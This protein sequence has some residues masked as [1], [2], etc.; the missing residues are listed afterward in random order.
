M[1]YGKD[2]EQNTSPREQVY[3]H[4]DVF[5]DDI[6]YQIFSYSLLP[7]IQF[8]YSLVCKQWYH[9]T[10]NETFYRNYYDIHSTSGLNEF[11]NPTTTHSD[12]MNYLFDWSECVSHLYPEQYEA[13]QQLKKNIHVEDVNNE[14][15]DS[16]FKSLK[17]IVIIMENGNRIVS[18]F[19]GRSSWQSEDLTFF[20][21]A[22][23][24]PVLM[25]STVKQESYTMEVSPYR[26]LHGYYMSYDK[27]W[28]FEQLKTVIS[29]LGEELFLNLMEFIVPN[30]GASRNHYVCDFNP[31]IVGL[32]KF[33]E[34]AHR[35]KSYMINDTL[36]KRVLRNCQKETGVERVWHRLLH[37]GYRFVNENS[38]HQF[39][40]HEREILGSASRLQFLVHYCKYCNMEHVA[41]K[42]INNHIVE[43][44]E[45][46][47]NL[48]PMLLQ[49]NVILR[50]DIYEK[51]ET[52]ISTPQ[53]VQ[54][55]DSVIDILQAR[56]K[57][58]SKIDFSQ[59]VL[60]RACL[61]ANR[62]IMVY[63]SKS[64]QEKFKT[65]FDQY[66]PFL[67]NRHYLL[68]TK[69]KKKKNELVTPEILENCDAVVFS[70]SSIPDEQYA[71]KYREALKMLHGTKKRVV[72][73]F[74]K[75]SNLLTRV[76]SDF[77]DMEV[78]R[79]RK[80]PVSTKLLL[81]YAVLGTSG[82]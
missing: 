2:E 19:V 7:I 61:D 14:W 63:D 28:F 75:P 49:N 13:L 81:D 20:A 51:G 62:V 16:Q 27:Q 10:N 3:H 54:D 38:L 68:S 56:K 23:D 60:R 64:E 70:V 36:L 50:K 30:V 8:H 29:N 80:D 40:F 67:Q 32:S 65:L 43:I 66:Y 48:C 33:C 22:K 24:N 1:I 71:S 78:V 37:C 79:L 45:E 35:I 47:A 25:E 4:H 11:L 6:L 26:T 31:Y 21:S 17:R 46:R 74:C 69:S 58:F 18:F 57:F 12:P 9:L 82:I 59:D 34:D 52:C 76:T 15:S 39:F 72:F 77:L 5:P 44:V 55:D 42:L 41:E 73:G 53:T